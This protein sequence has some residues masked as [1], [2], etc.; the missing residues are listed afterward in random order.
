MKKNLI[1]FFI[2]V[3]ILL[4]TF[5]T[6]TLAQNAIGGEKLQ[7]LLTE[8]HIII[9]N[10]LCPL[11]NNVEL[12]FDASRKTY[13]RDGFFQCRDGDIPDKNFIHPSSGTWKL[14][15][16]EK[17]VIQL[18]DI[19]NKYTNQVTRIQL[20]F[21]DDGNIYNLNNKLYSYRLENK[22]ERIENNARRIEAEELKLK[23]IE[24]EKRQLAIKR[25]Q[26]K[27]RAEQ[28]KIKQDEEKRRIEE[29]REIIRK[30]EAEEEAKLKREKFWKDALFFIIVSASIVGSYYYINRFYKEKIVI[31]KNQIVT[32]LKN[33]WNY[34]SEGHN[35]P[36]GKY[37]SVFLIVFLLSL[38]VPNKYE[39]GWG[40]LIPGENEVILRSMNPPSW[41][42]VCRYAT[43]D[44]R[45]FEKW[46]VDRCANYYNSETEELANED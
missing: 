8:N 15:D 29:E 14:V 45:Y 21:G 25:E 38:L 23:K 3:S 32:K 40:K 30:K 18:D 34:K 16:S 36:I 22:K 46:Q 5:Y 20:L 10:F 44:R 28:L 4:T 13:V 33:I 19:Q 6:N 7:K 2:T 41:W 12:N 24:E 26:E 9:Y 37:L 42:V 31:Y 35:W 11:R 27:I 43:K 17:D 1:K 39:R